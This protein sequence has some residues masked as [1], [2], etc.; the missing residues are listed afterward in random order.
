MNIAAEHH[1]T[2]HTGVYAGLQ[3]PTFETPA[4]Y[5]M[6]HIIGADAVGMSTVPEV[7]VA[8][9][10]VMEVFAISVISDMGYPPEQADKVTHDFVLK[11]AAEAEPKMR[12]IIV[13]LLQQI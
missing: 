3:G 6:L 4:E 2:C 10:G 5:K 7:I 8:R 9:H 1:I 11:K 13:E 12:K